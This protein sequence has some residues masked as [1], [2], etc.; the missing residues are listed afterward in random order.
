MERGIMGL[1]RAIGQLSSWV[2]VVSSWGLF[3]LMGI[4]I[5]SI[6]LRWA[7]L[8]LSGAINLST[9]FLVAI[10]YLSLAYT[11]LREQHVAVE[12]FVSRLRGRCRTVVAIIALTLAFIACTFMGWASWKHA[13]ISWAGRE[14]MDGAPFYPIYPAK[15]ALAI[16]VSVLWLQLMA[17]LLKV[18]RRYR[19]A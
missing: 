13:W 11:Q 7:G 19:E 5:A 10:V 16:G 4:G 15:I 9:Y 18:L 3:V 6:G 17:D 2:N 12:F 14:R 1:A 8:G